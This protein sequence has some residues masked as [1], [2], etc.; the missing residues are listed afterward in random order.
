MKNSTRAGQG[1]T[2]AKEAERSVSWSG[3]DDV[4]DASSKRQKKFT[5]TEGETGEGMCLCFSWLV[6]SSVQPQMRVPAAERCN[7]NRGN[8]SNVQKRK[9][10]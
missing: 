5:Q 7:I 2:N 3:S 6:I 8:R 4:I 9:S 1:R 10:K